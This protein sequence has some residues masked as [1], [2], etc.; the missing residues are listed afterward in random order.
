MPY[1]DLT[2]W[3]IV[4]GVYQTM[5]EG[6]AHLQFKNETLCSSVNVPEC[7]TR[8]DAQTRLDNLMDLWPTRTEYGFHVGISNIL[9]DLKDYHTGYLYPYPMRCMIAINGLFLD[10]IGDDPKSL[11]VIAG[12]STFAPDRV[13]K[14]IELGEKVLS[15]NGI[16]WERLAGTRLGRENMGAN[17]AAFHRSLVI[18]SFGKAGDLYHPTRWGTTTYEIQ[19]VN[20]NVYTLKVPITF[21]ASGDC[22]NQYLKLVSS[23]PDASEA[24]K[25]Q[26]NTVAKAFEV[27]LE[28][29]KK[30]NLPIA[31]LPKSDIPTLVVREG[32]DTVEAPPNNLNQ[33]FVF[34]KR[35]NTG[36]RYGR[37]LKDLSFKLVKR[38]IPKL[39]QI[40]TS[41]PDVLQYGIW[42][43]ES[44]IK[45]GIIYLDTFAPSQVENGE[46]TLF[47]W[48]IA[49][50][51]I[52]IQLSDKADAILFDVRGNPG[53]FGILAEA[54][55]QLFHPEVAQIYAR[56]RN[57]E[58]NKRWVER[59]EYMFGEAIP[60]GD[61]LR[62]AEDGSY[63]TENYPLWTRA[64]VTSIGQV[65]SKP[66]GV[67]I[68]GACYSACDVFAA[69]VQDSKAGLII[70]EDLK[71]GGGGGSRW[72]SYNNL[73]E[74]DQ[75]F[76]T[77]MPNG[78]DIF[79]AYSQLLRSDGRLIENAGVDADLYIRKS[80]EDIQQANSSSYYDKIAE[81]LVEYGKYNG[82]G[83]IL[84]EVQPREYM[85]DVTAPGNLTFTVVA[86]GVENI[87]ILSDG[88]VISSQSVSAEEPANFTFT[89]DAASEDVGT[90]RQFE[91]IGTLGDVVKF[92]TSRF[93]HFVPDAGL[94]VP[95]QM[96]PGE[97]YTWDLIDLNNVFISNL[98][99]TNTTWHLGTD[100]TTGV[101]ALKATVRGTQTYGA[102]AETLMTAFFNY[103]DVDPAQYQ[104]TVDL[105]IR[106]NT[107]LQ[108]DVLTLSIVDAEENKVLFQGEFSGSVGPVDV[109]VTDS[110]ICGKIITVD[111]YFSSD[112]EI[113]GEER[114][115]EYFAFKYSGMIV[116]GDFIVDDLNP[117]S[118][119][120]VL[121]FPKTK[122]IAKVTFLI[123]NTKDYRDEDG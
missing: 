76:G 50:R 28:N 70:G 77:P 9:Y 98:L 101:T 38:N 121:T 74:A 108:F 45:L 37:R 27:G 58:W 24:E 63:Y 31:E 23:K 7:Q 44:D 18:D 89:V 4:D 69:D 33:T 32:N 6:Y 71:T 106:V 57:T 113:N 79:F 55:I 117:E 87:E 99:P 81:T 109:G 105:N 115:Q 119:M 2:K 122:L 19:R 40:T 97:T 12:Y 60:E 29:A 116:E 11:P 118:H 120:A 47:D 91:F 96:L 64:D 54:L 30:Y 75:S 56:L 17:D 5:T 16:P 26:A 35:M 22:I 15:I 39:E 100:E 48:L 8:A 90:Y 82:K 3:G 73:A 83:S 46:M 36:D 51:S 111:A 88:A 107:E 52:L 66:V 80:L 1:D 104:C 61:A 10:L 110:L 84:V 103:T 95:V 21:L 20:G 13:V 42:R 65:T 53:G 78:Q 41:A 25:A 93:L 49:V 14:Q 72:F 59:I 34:P 67:Y 85:L 102:N 68:N 86:A 123:R 92:R 62:A 43:T 114:V 94:V 112:N